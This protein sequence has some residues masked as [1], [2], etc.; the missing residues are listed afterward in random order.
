MATNFARMR[1]LWTGPGGPGYSNLDVA[2]AAG[3]TAT[4]LNAIGTAWNAYWTTVLGYLPNDWTINVMSEVGIIQDS[5]GILQSTMS[6]TTA[7]SAKVGTA[8][9]TWA[10]AAGLVTRL[11]TADIVAGTRVRGKTYFVPAAATLAFDS[12]GTLSSTCVSDFTSAT[13]TLNAAIVTAGARRVVYSPTHRSLHDV[14]GFTVL[15][16]SAVL[17]SRRA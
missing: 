16:R 1:T 12:D 9:G 15:D 10:G 13:T 5:D 3:I 6:I 4:P 2:A 17:R 8:A 11:Q 14:S 7:G